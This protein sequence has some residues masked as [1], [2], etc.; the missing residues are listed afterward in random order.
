[1]AMD[2]QTGN[3]IHPDKLQSATGD[4]RKRLVCLPTLGVGEVVLIKGVSFKVKSI[5]SRGRVVLQM[6]QKVEE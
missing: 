3:F 5:V 4:E 6:V 2:Q 1:M